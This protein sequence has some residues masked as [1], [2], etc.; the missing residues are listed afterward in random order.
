MNV[1]TLIEVLS[2]EVKK[3]DRENANIEFWLEEQE[4][5]ITSMSGFSFSPDIIIR[6]KKIETPIMQPATFKKKY[7]STVKKIENKIKKGVLEND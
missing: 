1:K 5:D 2:K 7:T 6:L 4:L 3:E